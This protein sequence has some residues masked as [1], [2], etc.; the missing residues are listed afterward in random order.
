MF[1][2]GQAADGADGG[3][4]LKVMGRELCR[5]MANNEFCW[6]YPIL[7]AAYMHILPSVVLTPKQCQCVSGHNI[8]Q[9]PWWLEQSIQRGML[10]KR[11]CRLYYHT[12]W[13]YGF[14]N[15]MHGWLLQSISPI[16]Y[17]LEGAD[18]RILCVLPTHFYGCMAVAHKPWL[19]SSCHCSSFT[20]CTQ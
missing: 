17:S 11:Q 4:P 2:R 18:N 5:Q 9:S 16:I 20:D 19:Y 6:L 15:R 3:K 8:I 7:I 1:G 13:E 14:G 12:D 10:H